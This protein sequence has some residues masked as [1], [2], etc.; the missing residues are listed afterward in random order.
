VC[1]VLWPCLLGALLTANKLFRI[2]CMDIRVIIPITHSL[3]EPM[4][5]DPDF[6][7][8]FAITKELRVS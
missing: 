1:L 8:M 2:L 4:R 6:G 5:L 7:K 3:L